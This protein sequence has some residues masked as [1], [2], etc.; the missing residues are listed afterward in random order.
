MMPNIA[1]KQKVGMLSW[2]AIVYMRQLI[3]YIKVLKQYDRILYMDTDT[4]VVNSLNDMFNLKFDTLVG[5]FHQDDRYRGLFNVAY[6][7][8][9]NNVA[10]YIKETYDIQEYTKTDANAKNIEVCSGVQMFN[11]RCDESE[12]KKYD[13]FMKKLDDMV[14]NEK[15]NDLFFLVD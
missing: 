13:K 12:F 6:L 5:T 2:P 3:P 15:L 10:N 7:G 14:S 8:R 1:K 9:Y 4:V 11:T